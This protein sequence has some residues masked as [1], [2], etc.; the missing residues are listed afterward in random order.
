MGSIFAVLTISE[1]TAIHRAQGGTCPIC[2][3]PLRDR[4]AE[5]SQGIM[6]ALDHDHRI[7]RTLLDQGMT[8]DDALRRSIRGLVCSWDNHRLLSAGRDDPAVFERAAR[9]LRDWPALKVLSHA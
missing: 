3:K 8:P 4:Y 2:L 1:W 7:E 9:Y 5:G 6:A